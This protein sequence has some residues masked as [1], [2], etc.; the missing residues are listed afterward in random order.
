MRPVFEPDTFEHLLVKLTSEG[1]T[2]IIAVVYRPPSP[3]GD[4]PMKFFEELTLLFDRLATMST[5]CVITGDVN[6]HFERTDDLPTRHFIELL[7]TFGLEQHVDRPTYSRSGGIID[8]VITSAQLQPYEMNVDSVGFSDH[9][10]VQWKLNIPVKNAATYITK[11]SRLWKKFDVDKFRED[12][13]SSTLCNCMNIDIANDSSSCETVNDKLVQLYDKTLSDLLNRHAP[14]VTVTTRRRPRTDPWFDTDCRKA[15]RAARKLERRYKHYGSEYLKSEWLKSLRNSHDLVDEKR[16]SF[17]RTKVS[18]Q[19]NARQTWKVIDNILCRE[20]LKN[21]TSLTADTFAEFFHKK[22]TDIR[23]ATEGSEKPSFSDNTS[24]CE[25]LSFTSL[26]VGDIIRLIREAPMKQCALDPIPT[27]LLKDCIDLLAPFIARI[28]NNSLSTGYVPTAFNESYITPFLKKP[29]L[30]MNETSNY[31]PVSNLSVL[32]KTLERAVSRQ[33]E[34]YL[35][36]A[37]LFP[38]HQSAYRKHHSTET[39]LLRVCSDLIINLDKGDFA[40]MA[41]LDL[42]SAFDTVDREILLERMSRSFGVQSVALQWLRSYLTNRTEYVLLDGVKSP[43]RTMEFGVPQGSV[44][45]PLLFLLYTADL[46][47]ISQRHKVEAHFYADD[48]QMYVHSKPDGSTFAENQLIS[49]LDEMARWLRSNRLCLNSSKTQFMRCSTVRRAVRLNLTPISFCGEQFDPLNEVR[50]LG[51]VLDRSLTMQSQVSRTVSSCFYQLRRIKTSLKALPFE[52]AR[53]LVN[54]FVINRIDYCNSLLAGVPQYSFDRLQR[55]MNAAARIVC[56]A[57]RRAHISELLRHQLHWL[58]VPQRVHFKL[59]LL[60]YKSLHGMA[61]TYL[62]ELCL[63]VGN[64]DARARLRSA[65]HG[66]LT[67]A[68]TETNFGCRAFA[69]TGPTVWNSLPVSIREAGSLSTFKSSLKT[70]LFR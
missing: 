18:E 10:L 43:V 67:V 22:V 55:V 68:R 5:P 50:N 56:R 13:Q 36:S 14:V 66:D 69:V 44:L 48:S 54:C 6:V 35:T 51:V 63:S 65:S 12:L 37:G 53:S 59:A 19:S 23:A 33:L 21:I 20:K 52:I 49:C 60:V 40:T 64:N 32:S 46:E 31:R 57:G 15:K 38:S 3:S 29:G 7:A 24:G 30:E 1:A 70:F 25:L 2:C 42:S 41:F 45:G 61:P 9:S 34:R 27:W 16:S 26:E 47:R 4:V 62:T 58:P 39:I 17:W 8:V 11:E 28:I